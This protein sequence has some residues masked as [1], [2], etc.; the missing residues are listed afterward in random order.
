MNPLTDVTNRHG[1]GVLAMKRTG[2]HAVIHWLL[3]HFDGPCAHL[4]NCE[5]LLETTHINP[6][7]R[8]ISRTERHALFAGFSSAFYLNGA[9]QGHIRH[10]AVHQTFSS[11]RD[12]MLAL[13]NVEA[14]LRLAYRVGPELDA[15]LYNFEDMD[16]ATFQAL[17]TGLCDRGR[18][19]RH[20]GIVVVRDLPNFVASRLAGGYLITDAV[21]E[22][23]ASHVQAALQPEDHPDTVFVRYPAWHASEAY[24][25]ELAERLGLDFTDRGRDEVVPFGPVGR[26]GSSFEQLDHHGRASQM[27]TFERWRA[28]V[29]DERWRAICR[30][31]Q[32]RRLSASC[33]GFDP[34]EDLS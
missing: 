9:F 26:P 27:P 23:W 12:R 22:A 4:N 17:P 28:F 34:L 8:V 2:H 11:Q 3:R 21:L 6:P 16:L 20:V 31:P 29:D 25:R 10:V 15:Y 24:R 33:F 1:F 19:E 13:E 30:Q 14:A 32:L 18:S 5:L 7:P